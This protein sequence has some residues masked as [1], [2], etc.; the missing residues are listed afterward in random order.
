MQLGII[1]FVPSDVLVCASLLLRLANEIRYQQKLRDDLE[2]QAKQ[3][4]AAES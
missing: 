2:R 1:G 3:E 4:E